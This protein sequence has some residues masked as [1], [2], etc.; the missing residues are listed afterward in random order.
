VLVVV[1]VLVLLDAGARVE[2]GEVRGTT[3][4]ERDNCG[5]KRD[6]VTLT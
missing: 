6:D 5:E 4:R 3:T 1:L 2:K